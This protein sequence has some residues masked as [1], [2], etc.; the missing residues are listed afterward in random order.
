MMLTLS[1][2]SILGSQ[3]A[4]A[5]Q[6]DLLHRHSRHRHLRSTVSLRI[7]GREVCTIADH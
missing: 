6:V 5:A 1:F 2:L 4:M 3:T 7:S